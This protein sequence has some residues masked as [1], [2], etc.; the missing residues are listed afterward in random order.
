M[1]TQQ[2]EQT[3]KSIRNMRIC[4]KYTVSNVIIVK[5][6]RTNGIAVLGVPIKTDSG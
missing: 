6:A 5:P 1:K 3:E 2:N 4:L